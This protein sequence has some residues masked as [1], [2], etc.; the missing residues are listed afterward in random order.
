MKLNRAVASIIAFLLPFGV[1]TTL[2]LP[3]DTGA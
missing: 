3:P 2:A 1:V